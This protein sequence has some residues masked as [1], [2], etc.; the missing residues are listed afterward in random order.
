[1][2]LTQKHK[3]VLVGSLYILAGL[4]YFLFSTYPHFLQI[5]SGHDERS[6]HH[7]LNVALGPILVVTG[8]F[9]LICQPASLS[10]WKLSERDSKIYWIS[11]ILAIFLSVEWFESAVR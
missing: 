3:S 8:L 5:R 4:V 10:P 7:L 11:T 6:Y 2:T 9:H 1:M